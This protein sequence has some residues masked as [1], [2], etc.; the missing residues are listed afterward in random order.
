MAAGEERGYD[1]FISY[2]HRLD[3]AIT[4]RLQ[5]ELE[6][7]AK[8]WYR[9]RALHVFRDQTS[10]AASPHL[11]TTIEEAMSGSAWLILIA[12]P[13]SA[14]SAWVSREISW[15]RA[16]RPANH[17]LVAFTRGELVWDESASDL[18]WGATT[19][20]PR[21]RSGTRSPRSRA[22]WTCAGPRTRKT[23]CARRTRAC[24][25]PWPTWPRRSGT[26][27]RTP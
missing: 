6:H 2:S 7:F 14:Q 1:A 3:A 23:A 27:P 12:Y 20:L 13:E 21:R 18:D 22:G 10:L 25:T 4:A 16:N 24:R 8:P 15:W 26:C 5:G 9:V 11:W 17:L 19:A